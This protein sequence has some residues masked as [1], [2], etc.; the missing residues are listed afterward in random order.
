MYSAPN[1]ILPIIFG[2][3]MDNFIGKRCG[4]LILLCICLIGQFFFALSTNIVK[5]N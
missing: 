5:I 2:F 3:I 4:L 1:F